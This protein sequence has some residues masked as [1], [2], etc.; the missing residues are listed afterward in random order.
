M[1]QFISDYKLP[2]IKE[3]DTMS[4]LPTQPAAAE[5]AKSNVFLDSATLAL[6]TKG[7]SATEKGKKSTHVAATALV[8]K[9]FNDPAYFISPKNKESKISQTDWDAMTTAITK[10]FTAKKQKLINAEVS[11]LSE[12]DKKERN[13]A[14]MSIGAYRSALKKMVMKMADSESGGAS[15]STRDLYT[16]TTE[17]LADIT[18]RIMKAIGDD[19]ELGFDGKAVVKLVNSAA[20]MAKKTKPKAS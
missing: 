3:D 2:T 20:D 4:K 19:K 15:R 7:F 1:L 14:K 13:A 11:K 8:N 6:I 17:S 5:P 16:I 9:G 18:S 12:A 10:S